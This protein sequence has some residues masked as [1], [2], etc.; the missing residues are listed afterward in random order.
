MQESARLHAEIDS[1]S[2]RIAQ[3]NRRL[4]ELHNV[5]PTRTS[6]EPVVDQ[7]RHY[8]SYM[9]TEDIRQYE[10]QPKSARAREMYDEKERSDD[11]QDFMQKSLQKSGFQTS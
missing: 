3:C 2:R 1:L 10:S 5:K 4:F 7:R 11:Y 6:S 8:P 9:T